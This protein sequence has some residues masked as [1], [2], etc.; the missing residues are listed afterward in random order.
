MGGPVN[1]TLVGSPEG[2]RS[3][4]QLDSE[5]QEETASSLGFNALQTSP[6]EGCMGLVEEPTE[7]RL[8]VKAA[9]KARCCC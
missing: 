3:L 6:L 2:L 4:G 9:V 7:S 5:G 8:S 1:G